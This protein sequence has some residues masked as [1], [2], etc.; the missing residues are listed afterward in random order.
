[1]SS[2]ISDENFVNKGLQDFISCILSSP[3]YEVEVINSID[4]ST[5]LF[6]YAPLCKSLK[7][8]GGTER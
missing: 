8:Y 6:Q 2:G 1:M 3:L 5:D 7:S 4:Q